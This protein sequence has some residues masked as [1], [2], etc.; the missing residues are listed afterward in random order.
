MKATYDTETKT[1]KL[2]QT[3]PDRSNIE[4]RNFCNIHEISEDSAKQ[5]NAVFH[6][7]YI[8]KDADTMQDFNRQQKIW[9]TKLE[10]LKAE[11]SRANWLVVILMFLLCISF[12]Y[13]GVIKYENS[14]KSLPITKVETVK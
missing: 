5:M 9:D 14:N 2:H 4:Y 6:N 8:C 13:I 3:V 11:L 12:G 7:E 1:I 10:H